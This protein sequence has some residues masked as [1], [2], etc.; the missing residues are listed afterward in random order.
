MNFIVTLDME[1]FCH[2]YK[3]Y[4]DLKRERVEKRWWL[5]KELKQEVGDCLLLLLIFHPLQESPSVV[6][7]LVDNPVEKEKLDAQV[8]G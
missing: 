6:F 2:N 3:D 4:Y 8:E 7:M 5:E 1:R